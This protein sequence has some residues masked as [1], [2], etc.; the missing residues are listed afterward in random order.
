MVELVAKGATV[1][2]TLG[3]LAVVAA[4]EGSTKKRTFSIEAPRGGLPVHAA[5]VHASQR[6]PRVY[7]QVMDAVGLG[8][9]LGGASE[10]RPRRRPRMR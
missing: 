10:T 1:E 5:Y 4:S 7:D 6:G 9:G 3:V 2:F 8:P